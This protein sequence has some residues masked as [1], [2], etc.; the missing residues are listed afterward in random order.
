MGELATKIEVGIEEIILI[1][2]IAVSIVAMVALLPGDVMVIKKLVSWVGLGY[3]LYKIDLAELFF[4]EKRKWMDGLLIFSY[5]CLILKDFFTFSKELAGESFYLFDFTLL[6]QKSLALG[7][8]IYLLQRPLAETI[9]L[10]A[11]IIG[12]AILA[13]LAV[14]Q[15]FSNREI[16]R[17]SVLG[18]FHD[19]LPSSFGDRIYRMGTSFAVFFAFFV[20]V[21]N[22]IMEWLAWVVYSWITIFALLFYFL[23]FLKFHRQFH[24]STM[25]YRVGNA[26]HEF[27][28]RFLALFTDKSTVFIGIS[29]MLVLHLLTD[30]GA[31]IIPSIFGRQVSYFAS[32]G[33]GHDPVLSL[34]LGD[35]A[36]AVGMTMK[37]GVGLAYLLNIVAVLVLFLGPAYIWR[38]V[39]YDHPISPPRTLLVFFYP[40]VLTFI[41]LPVFTIARLPPGRDV[42]IA[43][44]DVL[45]QGLAVGSVW[46]A[47]LLVAVL[48]ILIVSLMVFPKIRLFLSALLVISISV[49]LAYY[50][51]LYFMSVAASYL[52]LLFSPGLPPLFVIVFAI[53]FV[54]TAL[55]YLAG[56]LGFAF[57]PWR[58]GLVKLQEM[59]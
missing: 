20:I 49:F 27:Y 45:T 57:L 18:I 7:G 10:Y 14:S 32:L 5:F 53:F 42:S 4:G 55:F 13:C 16:R 44:V 11:F 35:M 8:K 31:F 28:R 46:R 41:L 52:L 37:A 38:S 15:L 9:E 30:V 21:F 50:I 23:F 43:G 51:S 48:F 24:I 22:L 26:G 39:Y 25:I 19:G 6:F 36:R 17:P 1:A 56:F 29:G 12:V 47:L 3:L 58:H 54:M 34:F 2:L 40:A 59:E 33:P